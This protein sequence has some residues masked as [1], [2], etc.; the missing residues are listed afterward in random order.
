M[1]YSPARQQA[2]A[3]LITNDDTRDYFVVSVSQLE[4]MIGIKLLS[5]L[6]QEVRDGGMLLPKPV[7]WRGRKR[8]VKLDDEF[9]LRDFTSLVID[10]INR[11]SKQQTARNTM[12][13]FTPYA[14]ESDVVRIGG[15]EIG[16]RTDRV[17]L[18]GNLV[19][20]QAK[21]GLVLAKELQALINQV[22][23]TLEAEKRLT[24]RVRIKPA[25]EVNNPF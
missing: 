23:R 4:K 2:G 16:N 13:H 8:T 1:I 20:T 15:L 10:A 12:S 17:S 24:E 21:T 9:L 11:A 6:P 3:C 14:N 19:L 5:G 22:V 25:R 7:S 18:T